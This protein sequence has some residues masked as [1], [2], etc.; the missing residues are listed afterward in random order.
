VGLSHNDIANHYNVM[1]AM[2]QFHGWEP[3]LVEDYYAFERDLYV[4][5]LMAVVRKQHEEAQQAQ[6]R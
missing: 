3:T 5:Q 6:R 2:K 4:E 1:F